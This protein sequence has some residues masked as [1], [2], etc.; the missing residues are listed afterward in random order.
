METKKYINKKIHTDVESYEVYHIDY[1]NDTATARR[2][3]RE[4]TP[5]FVGMRCVNQL[6][7]YAS[8]VIPDPAYQPFTIQRKPNG[9]WGYWVKDQIYCW[10]ANCITQEGI[11]NQLKVPG[12]FLEE[13]TDGKK[14]LCVYRM[15]KG[16][17]IGRKF[18]KLGELEDECK[19]FYDYNF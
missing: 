16:G 17:K 10:D 8:P 3:K 6:D 15:T 1:V 19:Y 13:G 4:F 7:Q 12:S 9:V 11:D 14:F 18:V 2:V 5:Q